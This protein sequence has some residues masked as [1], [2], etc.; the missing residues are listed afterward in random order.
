MGKAMGRYRSTKLVYSLLFSKKKFIM[1]I[2]NLKEYFD[3]AISAD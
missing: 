3:F 1:K 2:R